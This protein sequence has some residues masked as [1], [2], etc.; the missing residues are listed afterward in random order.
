MLRRQKH[1]P[2]AGAPT[3]TEQTLSFGQ[4][5][6]DMATR[7]LFRDEQELPL[8][9]G[10]YALLKLLLS[11]PRKPLS[12]ATLV[13]LLSEREHETFDRRIDVQVSRLRRL[14]EDDPKNPRYIQT[15]WGHGYVFVP[16]GEAL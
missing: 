8:T 16:D 6:L 9:T 7:K 11:S 3:D 12:R 2:P 10:Q 4:F 14:L 15:V 13:A 5:T 1:N